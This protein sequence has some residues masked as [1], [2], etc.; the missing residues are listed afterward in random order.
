MGHRGVETHYII[1][2]AIPNHRV[3]KKKVRSITLNDNLNCLCF[4][5]RLILFML[6]TKAICCPP[7][8]LFLSLRWRIATVAVQISEF[9][10]QYQPQMGYPVNYLSIG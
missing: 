1:T 3:Q 10:H 5:Q 4:I 9:N 8:P 2:R 7:F 6:R